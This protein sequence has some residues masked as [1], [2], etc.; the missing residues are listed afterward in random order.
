M[1]CNPVIRHYVLTTSGQR[2]SQSLAMV[3][4]SV[5]S[6]LSHRQDGTKSVR[7]AYT[8]DLPYLALPNHD[9][10]AFKYKGVVRSGNRSL[11]H[12]P[13]KILKWSSHNG[14]P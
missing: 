5:V 3:E 10:I 2:H 1:T 11:E 9:A 6:V 7:M 13:S 8:K 12:K 14:S 4:E